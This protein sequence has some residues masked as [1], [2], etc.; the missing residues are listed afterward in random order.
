VY[1]FGLNVTVVKK[2]RWRGHSIQIQFFQIH[3]VQIG[4]QKDFVT[5]KFCAHD[6][7]Y[8]NY[9]KKQFMAKQCFYFF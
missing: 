6:G 3:A 7:V 8:E 2:G 4:K 9:I 5:L 1:I